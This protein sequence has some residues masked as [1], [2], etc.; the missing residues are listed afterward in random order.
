M[1]LHPY[2]R[3]WVADTRLSTFSRAF[4]IR[5]IFALIWL[6]KLFIFDISCRLFWFL[7]QHCLNDYI[8][9]RRN[10][11]CTQTSGMDNVSCP[12]RNYQWVSA[13]IALKIVGSKSAMATTLRDKSIP[14]PLSDYIWS[15]SIGGTIVHA[16]TKRDI[17]AKVPVHVCVRVHS[18]TT[19]T[20]LGADIYF[21]LSPTLDLLSTHSKNVLK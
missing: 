15:P 4:C 7:I 14:C 9:L 18:I 19:L 21:C 11:E 17:F 1:N 10:L 3:L 20:M 6:M 5:P 13:V 16:N 8:S 12:S 2:K